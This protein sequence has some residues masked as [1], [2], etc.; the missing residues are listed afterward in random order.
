YRESTRNAVTKSHQL[1]FSGANESV[2]YLFGLNYLNQDGIFN[3][4]FYKRYSARVNTEIKINRNIRVGENLT[5]NFSRKN[6]FEDQGEANIVSWSYRMNPWIPVY[7][8]AGEFA[9]TKAIGSGNGQN[10]VAILER[11]K[12]NYNNFIRVFGNFY[13]DADILPSLKFRTSLGIDDKRSN[14][15]SMQMLDPEFSESQGRNQL[16]EGSSSNLRYVWSNTLNFTRQ[17]GEK[18][19]FNL[20]GGTEF[21]RD[22]IGKSMSATRYGY[23]FEDNVSTWTLANGGTRDLNNTAGW[24]GEMTLFGI[25]GRLDYSYNNRYLLTAIVRRDG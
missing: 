4:T 25:F 24:N 20:L 23:L 5:I 11:R 6:N 9:G 2:N 19:H 15:Y 21:I 13:L 1:T 8:I 10:P 7:D 22:G 18:H 16:T 12:D 3:H 17:I 14:Y